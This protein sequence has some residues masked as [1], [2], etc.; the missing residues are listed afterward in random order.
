MSKA[1]IEGR[2]L[3]KWVGDN[4]AQ[5]VIDGKTLMQMAT[6][7]F[8]W[9]PNGFE[10]CPGAAQIADVARELG[11]KA[12]SDRETLDK[13]RQLIKELLPLI[14]PPKLTAEIRGRVSEIE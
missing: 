14:P 12:P 1:R 9:S 13:A 7:C 6:A 8:E 4:Y 5:A 11:L 2:L 3:D 10:K